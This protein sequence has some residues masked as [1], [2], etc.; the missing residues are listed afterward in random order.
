MTIGLQAAGFAIGLSVY[1]VLLYSLAAGAVGA[2][3]EVRARLAEGRVARV[4][5]ELVELDAYRRRQVEDR[6]A[7][8]AE[9]R[10]RR[11][12]RAA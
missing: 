3:R 6:E 4:E 8:L 2:V 5:R 1:A 7:R 12:Q 9:R 11:T 10:A